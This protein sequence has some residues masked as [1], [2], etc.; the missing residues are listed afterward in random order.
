M[1][2][3]MQKAILD[4]TATAGTESVYYTVSGK[5]IFVSYALA[6][7]QKVPTIKAQEQNA[8]TDD[9]KMAGLKAI[10]DVML[11]HISQTTARLQILLKLQRS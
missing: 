2:T 10:V 7:A 6:S 9:A 4:T 8:L 1:L 11:L 3:F 5:N